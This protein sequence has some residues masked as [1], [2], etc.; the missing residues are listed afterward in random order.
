MIREEEVPIV[1][2]FARMSAAVTAPT[3]VVT[4]LSVLRS[5][6]EALD[7]PFLEAT[8]E[9]LRAFVESARLKLSTRRCYLGS[10]RSFYRHL[11]EYGWREDDPTARL[12]V[13]T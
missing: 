5:A 3:T 13:S 7:V 6:S 11:V 8:T 9:Q 10:L 12:V 1:E 2:E 4:R